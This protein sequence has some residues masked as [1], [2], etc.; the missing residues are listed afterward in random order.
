MTMIPLSRSYLNTPWPIA[1]FKVMS[2]PS[3]AGCNLA[4]EYFPHH[5]DN[6]CS[7]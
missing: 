5:H 6:K 1:A 7:R 3:G 2:K 4:C